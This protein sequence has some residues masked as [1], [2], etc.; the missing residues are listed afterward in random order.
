LIVH[1]FRRLYGA[2]P[3]HLTGLIA[4]FAVAGYA[5]WR[6]LGARPGA[7]LLWLVGAALLHDLVLA[8][9]YTLLDRA[10]GRSGRPPWWNHV[11]FPAAI[12]LLLL[13]IWFPEITRRSHGYGAT[14]GLDQSVYVDRWLA[15]CATLFVVSGLALLSRLLW[16]RWRRR[17]AYRRSVEAP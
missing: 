6:L 17:R 8:P 9:L 1:R 5:A 15:V 16:T 2:S 13:L 12:S 10:G 7:V 11:R 14:T 3:L 4:C